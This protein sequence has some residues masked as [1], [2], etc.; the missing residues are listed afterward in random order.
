MGREA[1]TKKPPIN[2]DV[3]ANDGGE[4]HTTWQPSTPQGNLPPV[5]RLISQQQQQGSGY[6]D[7]SKFQQQQGNRL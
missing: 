1:Q 5:L 6:S 2:T 3:A 7:L 4:P